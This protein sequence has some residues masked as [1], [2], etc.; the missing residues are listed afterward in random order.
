VGGCVGGHAGGWAVG[1]QQDERA[2][3]KGC[4]GGRMA[5]SSQ[6]AAAHMIL[7]TPAAPTVQHLSTPRH[8]LKTDS[9]VG[10]SKSWPWQTKNAP[11]QEPCRQQRTD[12]HCCRRPCV[13]H[14][15]SLIG[16]G[17]CGP[18]RWPG[19]FHLWWRCQR[20][21]DKQRWGS[22]RLSTLN[23]LNAQGTLA[24]G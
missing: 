8:N 7:T 16:R 20:G 5:G 15:S 4:G 1:G 13:S 10:A 11:K 23:G 19:H 24:Q 17:P 6:V 18:R 14:P 21:R 3:P 12:V 9:N 22:G 2:W